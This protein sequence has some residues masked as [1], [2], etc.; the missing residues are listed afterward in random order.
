MIPV[1]IPAYKSEDRMPQIRDR[2]LQQGIET[3]TFVR[4]NSIDNIYYTMAINEGLRRYAFRDD[5]DFCLILCDDVL[6]QPGCLKA[7]VEC[8]KANPLA[9]IISP[10]QKNAAGE[11]QWY[12]SLQSWPTGVHVVGPPEP[13]AFKTNWA[14]GA[15]FLVR[16][17]M[18]R[19][20]GL[21]DENMIF[22]C[23]DS[24][25]SLTAR[26]RGWE[27]WVE[28]KAEVQHEFRGCQAT[29]NMTLERIK[30]TD[31]LYFTNKWVSG[32]LFRDLEYKGGMI[33][34]D[35]ISEFVIDCEKYL[36]RTEPSS[37]KG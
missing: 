4:D 2:V 18:V 9:G 36:I 1:I 8:A 25:Y 35:K 22:V 23:S 19:E 13:E 11:I 17:E 3:E 21:L 7:M 10:V 32:R 27:C 33:R 14:S 15:V 16:T 6:L 31:M 30:V 24:D 34:Q 26:S 5:V 29:A 37:K 28:P 12:G 20:I